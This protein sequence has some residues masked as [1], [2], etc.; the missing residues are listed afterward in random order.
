M[1]TWKLARAI[2]LVIGSLPPDLPDPIPESIREE[3][4]L[5]DLNQAYLALHQP[6]NE[7]QYWQAWQRFRFEEAF[8]LQVALA[9]LRQAAKAQGAI[10]R[11]K[12]TAGLLSRFDAATPFQ[13]TQAQ[14]RV[15]EEI[16]QALSQT[17][18]MRRLLQGDVGSGKTVVALRAA[19]QV[20]DAGGQVALLAPTEILA[21]QHLATIRRLLGPLAEEGLLSQLD[22]PAEQLGTPSESSNPPEQVKPGLRLRLLTG[23]LGVAQRRQVLADLASGQCDL[24]I[25]THALLSDP[26]EF[27]NLGLVVVDEQHRFGVEQRDKLRGRSEHPAHLLVMTATPIPRTIAMTVF[28][29]LDVSTL[30]QLPPG[31]SPVTTHWVPANKPQWVDRVWQ[32]VREE[33]D[34]GHRAFVVCPRISGDQAE[35]AEPLLDESSTDLANVVDV[36]EQLRQTAALAGIDIGIVHGKLSAEAKDQAM[37]RFADGSTP[38]LVATVVIEVGIDVPQASIMVVLDADR[39]GLAQLHQLRGR[40]GRG[41]APGVCLLVAEPASD[42]PAAGRLEALVASQDG[43]VLAE[44]DL[45]LRREGDILGVNQSGSRRSLRLLRVLRDAKLISRTRQA[46]EPLV[47]QDPS[48]ANH[49]ALVHHLAS[50]LAQRQAFLERT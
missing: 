27:A 35:N 32:R 40:I 17:Q 10:A 1:P 31:R 46:A 20:A 6:I 9:Q 37:A 24:V 3:H 45:E 50:T 29:D 36:A 7:Q 21:N 15:G 41:Q 4:N 49:P 25:G 2:G 22:N 12:Q 16:S 30:D 26:V 44:T 42:T 48:L 5:L 11:P 34:A 47:E 33:V 19:L 8:T 28:G 38:V 18:P 43:F 14:Q 23:S 39:F 13:L